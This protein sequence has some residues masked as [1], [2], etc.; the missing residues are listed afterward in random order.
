MVM[1]DSVVVQLEL[2]LYPGEPWQGRSPRGLTRVHLGVI[3]KPEAE[4]SVSDLVLDP[5]QYDLF[6]AAIKDLPPHIWGG[7][8]SLLPL[9]G[10]SR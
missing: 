1:R 9:K 4:K 3:L 8:P 2:G 10:R 7:S 5:C 6:P